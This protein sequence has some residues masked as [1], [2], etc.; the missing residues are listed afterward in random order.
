MLLLPA[1]RP[2]QL[3]LPLPLDRA[4]PEVIPSEPTV[5]VRLV[6][7]LHR[8]LAFALGESIDLIATD[9]ET[10]R[11]WI[12]RNLGNGLAPPVGL[13]TT[14]DL[15]SNAHFGDVTGDD[16]PELLFRDSDGR[17]I[18]SDTTEADSSSSW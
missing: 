6:E 14:R 1:T 16:I 8:K 3:R 13:H 17:I 5:P 15:G 11:V 7:D 2:L 12:Y 9:E 4:L 18:H 10:S